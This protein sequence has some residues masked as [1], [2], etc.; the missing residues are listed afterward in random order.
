VETVAP[1]AADVL[2][3][4][5]V[6]LV[7]VPWF[8]L[9][10][11][12]SAP[13]PFAALD[14]RREEAPVWRSDLG[15]HVMGYHDALALLRDDRLHRGVPQMLDGAGI[16]DPVVRRQWLTS[17]L[18]APSADHDRM[19][20]LV[21][22]SFTPRAIADL[23]G[24]AAAVAERGAERGLEAGTI[25]AM[26]S[27][28]V[29]IPPAVFCRMIGAPDADAPMI[30]RLSAEILQIFARDPS[31]APH[32]EASTHELVGYVLGF[33]DR[34]RQAPRSGDLVSNLLAA[35]EGGERLSTDE[36]VALVIEVLEA[37]T[38]NTSSQLALVLHAAALEPGRWAAL[39]AEP[40]AIPAFVEE[41]S[42]LWPRITGVAK[43]TDDDLDVAGVAIPAGSTA[44]AMV[45]SAHRDP[46][47]FPDPLRFDPA[48]TEK[49][50]NL[51][52][53]SGSHYCIGANLA[54]L[55][56][57]AALEVLTRRWATIEPAGPLQIEVN[58][59]VVTVTSLPLE[60]TPG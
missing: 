47:A 5:P 35:E 39:R 11:D 6:P 34:R 23:R 13:D 12:L 44:F 22:P 8:D 56:M 33:V 55:E 41:A 36:L 9:V 27:L 46:A 3:L 29:G 18:G 21:S 43:S 38:D 19:R 32:I 28:A 1:Y 49:G 14:A 20:R 51:N 40:T 24:C 50:V 4:D 15:V 7:D 45:P 30:G 10:A 25:D 48:R 16:T 31:L 42:R 59:G 17:M 37:S 58:P 53:G 60:V 54:R 2:D 26:G 52:Y 57:G